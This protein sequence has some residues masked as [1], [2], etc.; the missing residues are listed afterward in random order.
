MRESRKKN[1]FFTICRTPEL[2]CEVTL[3]PI[4]RYS[5]LLDASIIFSDILVVPQAL[6]MEVEMLE[7]VG[8]HFP[9]PLR[10]PADIDKLKFPVDTSVALRY[11]YDAI[12]LTRKELKG[13]VPLFGFAGAPWT[14]MAYM[15]EGGGSKTLGKAKGFLFKYPEESH[16]L[17]RM[18]TVVIVDFL[19]DQVKAGAQVWELSPGDFETFSLPY[20]SEIADKVSAALTALNYKV[21]LVVFAR[22]AHYAVTSLSKTKYDV[23]SLDWTILPKEARKQASDK[24]LQ[25]NADP[26]ILY[27]PDSF[28][29]STVKQMMDDFRPLTKP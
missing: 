26:S 20:L 9:N 5:G 14:L 27:G 23:I 2:A 4:T 21:P 11:V 7:K 15:I 10:T 16:R 8:P 19:V 18:I 28:I 13:E 12:T 29:R 22:G 1:D 17:L 24:A 6:G 25:G 3:Q